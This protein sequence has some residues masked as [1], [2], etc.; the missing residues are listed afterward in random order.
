MPTPRVH[1]VGALR[2]IEN[3]PGEVT[4]GTE[5]RPL[6]SSHPPELLL[7]VSSSAVLFSFNGENSIALQTLFWNCPPENGVLS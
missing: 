6:A 2:I 1:M 3:S 5:S 4:L 7:T